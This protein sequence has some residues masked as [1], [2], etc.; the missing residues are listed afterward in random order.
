[1]NLIGLLMMLSLFYFFQQFE[2]GPKWDWHRI[3]MEG[4]PLS[5][6]FSSNFK[7]KHHLNRILFTFVLLH[8]VVFPTILLS[9]L[10]GLI[11]KPTHYPQINSIQE[12][13]NGEYSMV[14]DEYAFQKIL[15]QNEVN[16]LN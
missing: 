12:L 3:Q 14:G 4:H 10:F 13:I 1:M 8:S 6:G 11:A 9:A 7:P 16:Y 2:R 15:H 5:L